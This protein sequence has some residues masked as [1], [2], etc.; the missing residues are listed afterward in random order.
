MSSVVVRF[1]SG[2]VATR[3]TMMLA[4]R[5]AVS[6]SEREQGGGGDGVEAWRLLQGGDNNCGRTDEEL[7]RSSPS[8]KTRREEDLEDV[9]RLA[10]TALGEDERQSIG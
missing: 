1:R 3:A 7:E 2:V 10:R 6:S 5:R 8:P 4:W 9:V